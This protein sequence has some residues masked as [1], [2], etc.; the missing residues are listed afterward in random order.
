MGKRKKRVQRPML[1]IAQPELGDPLASMQ[2]D[3][4]TP[5]KKKVKKQN[6]QI[7]GHTRTVSSRKRAV[8]RESNVEYPSDDE[9]SQNRGEDLGNRMERKRFSDM[10][11]E[12]KVTYYAGMPF[13]VPKMKCE[14]VTLNKNYRGIIEDFHDGIV[15][16]KTARKEVEINIDEINDIQLVSL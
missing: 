5:K 4:R 6:K 3:Y 9:V 16:M 12:E 14:V 1:Y 13:H 11:I 10:S 15:F 2:S 7:S 8:S